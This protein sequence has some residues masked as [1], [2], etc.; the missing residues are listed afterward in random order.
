MFYQSFV[1]SIIAFIGMP[2][3]IY[4]I[5]KISKRLRKLA[6][7]AQ[8]N[9]SEFTTLMNESLGSIRIV[10]AYTSEG[11][12][13]RRMAKML[14]QIFK[15]NLKMLRVSLIASPMV[16]M[17][18]GI[19]IAGVIWYGGLQIIEGTTTQGAFFSFMVA[20]GMA[21]KPMKALS[22]INV[23][24]QTAL[25]SAKRLFV[26]MDSQP[27]I[28]DKK[29]AIE[30][31]KVKG[32]IE[33]K[34][35]MFRYNVFEKEKAF[36]IE[37]FEMEDKF[38]NKITIDNMNFKIKAGKTTALVGHSGSGKSTI[39]NLILRFYECQAGA[40]MLDKHDVKDLTI[41]SLRESMSLVSQDIVLFDGTI[42][43][44]IRYGKSDASD[45][46][47]I[48]AAKL[49]AADE[50]IDELSEGYDTNIGRNGL[51]LS[52]GQKQRISIARAI[53]RDAPILLLDEATSSLDPISERLIKQS[54]DKLMKGRTTIVIAHRLSTVMNADNIIVLRHGKVVEEGTHLKLVSKK[55]GEYANLYNKQF[56]AESK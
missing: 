42:K 35:V 44:N 4:P 28:R 8:E 6:L 55:K 37:D 47:V 50:F 43:E 21:Y 29:D 10:K 15:V 51:F 5:R 22:G 31:K 7:K 17:I 18:G 33:F 13:I 32:D 16:E 40:V 20:L 30:L 25:T 45:E 34:D 2:A 46:D 53:L 3:L 49:A 14:E 56:E 19:G 36:G 1:L 48:E 38:S 27:K 9:S 24:L 26:V 54:L 12:E 41:K 52:G 39:I 11:F 23:A